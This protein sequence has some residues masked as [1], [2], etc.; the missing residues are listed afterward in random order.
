MDS[1]IKA[2]IL[3][4]LTN[5]ATTKSVTIVLAIE[6]GSRAWG[7]AST[8]SDYDIRFIYSRP[9]NSYLRVNP[10]REVIELPITGELDINGWDI[11]KALG[12]MAK[13]NPAVLEWLSS[14]LIY[15]KHPL[16]ALLQQAAPSFFDPTRTSHHYL[17]MAQKNYKYL[18]TNLV[19]RKKYLYVLRP[20]FC[21]QWIQTHHTMPPMNFEEMF[22]QLPG[23]HNASLAA[24]I[25]QLLA[26][27]KAG[28]E[29]DRQ[30]RIAVLDTYIT[31]Q[32]AHYTPANF[33]TPTPPNY[34]SANNLLQ[35]ILHKLAQ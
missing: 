5:I 33:G 14:P 16:A 27:K 12:L 24:A 10:L 19:L 3:Q 23:S 1:T 31:Q 20:L 17:S 4:E 21:V 9:L 6:S 28:T 25:A 29:T 34:T 8:D 26:A 11:Q 18:Q 35:T 13:S 2:R 32:L 22:T 15:T 7:F 30:P